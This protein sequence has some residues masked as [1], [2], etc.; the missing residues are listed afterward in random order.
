MDYDRWQRVTEW[1]LII[2]SAV[3]LIAYAWQVIADLTGP[4]NA[5]AETLMW[6]T[7]GLFLADYVSNLIL[8]GREK[9]WRW[10]YTHWFDLCVVVLPMLRPLRILRLV[11]L[12]SVLQRTAGT[13]IRGKISIYVASASALLIFV[14]ALAVL[15]AERGQPGSNIE[16]FGNALWW[17]FVT[18]TT[19]GYGDYTP[20]TELGRFIA[21]GLMIGGIALLGVVTATLASWIVERVA[22]RDAEQEAATVGHIRSLETQLADM[23]GMLSEALGRER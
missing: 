23:R 12:L 13:A 4:A 1:P 5:L 19:V 21:V 15:D 20:V 6:I 10:F 8:I 11:T 22:E 18:V 3:F 16:T 2:A 14:A 17:A 9:R 7:W